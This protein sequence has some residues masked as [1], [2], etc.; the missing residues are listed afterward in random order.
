MSIIDARFLYKEFLCWY[1]KYR[2]KRK[3]VEKLS[4]EEE[5]AVAQEVSAEFRKKRMASIL[6]KSLNK[7][8][9][10]RVAVIVRDDYVV[11]A[12][13]IK[14]SG[15]KF[16]YEVDVEL[17]DRDVIKEILKNLGFKKV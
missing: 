4:R 6:K 2:K 15:K 12:I 5:E 10:K 13:W 14:D 8:K 1:E 16:L 7:Y 3:T 11:E 17:Y 9:D